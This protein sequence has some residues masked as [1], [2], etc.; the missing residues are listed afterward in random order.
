MGR[1]HAR[2]MVFAVSAL[3][4]ASLCTAA[5]VCMALVAGVAFGAAGADLL[6]ELPWQLS[7]RV[8]SGME[9]KCRPRIV[10]DS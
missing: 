8:L 3:T 5:G 6:C 1:M 4:A 10:G 9:S 2:Q 7:G